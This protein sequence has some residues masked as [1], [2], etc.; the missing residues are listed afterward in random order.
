[1]VRMLT[2][3]KKRERESTMYVISSIII[4]YAM[5]IVIVISIH[6]ISIQIISIQIISI[7]IISFIILLQVFFNEFDC[8]WREI[9]RNGLMI[10]TKKKEK[11]KKV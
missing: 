11:K 6:F 7:Q 10:W 9:N 2:M 4:M 1:M 3:P 8:S 5:L